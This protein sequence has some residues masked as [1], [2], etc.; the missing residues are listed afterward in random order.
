MKRFALQ[1]IRYQNNNL[2]AFRLIAIPGQPSKV[3]AVGSGVTIIAPRDPASGGVRITGIVIHIA[4][5]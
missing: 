5:P 1:A 4:T 3:H 2:V